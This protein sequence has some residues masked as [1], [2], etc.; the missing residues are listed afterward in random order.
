M[1]TVGD[2]I[3][4][5]RNVA[6]DPCQTLGQPTAPNGASSAVGIFNGSVYGFITYLS[7]WGETV[8]STEIG[9]IFCSNSGINLSAMV[10]PYAAV[11]ARFYWGYATGAEQQFI[12][13]TP[14][15]T[16]V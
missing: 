11:S 8:P 7:E 15:V 4:R 1:S 14:G 16:A 13:F 2:L 10:P 6:N 9:P 3:V 12:T 5:A